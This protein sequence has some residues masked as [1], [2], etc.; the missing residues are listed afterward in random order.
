MKNFNFTITLFKY[1]KDES[2]STF[3][4]N[5]L[6]LIFV[7]AGIYHLVGWMI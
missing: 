7:V 5:G 1:E 2:G 3:E 4:I 6:F